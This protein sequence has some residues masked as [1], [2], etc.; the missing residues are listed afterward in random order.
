M[1]GQYKHTA[2][3]NTVVIMSVEL[4]GMIKIGMHV[5]IYTN[6]GGYLYP[7]MA[8]LG[9]QCPTCTLHELISH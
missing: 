1:A 8:H 2:G 3:M 6:S 4:P 7:F 9:C 5:Y